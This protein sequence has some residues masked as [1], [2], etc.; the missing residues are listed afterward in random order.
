MPCA[1]RI[2]AFLAAAPAEKRQSILGAKWEAANRL[3]PGGAERHIH[4]A[5][6]GHP[7]GHE[8]LDE[9]LLFRGSQVGILVEE[10]LDFFGGHVLLEA[11]SFD[12]ELISG[13]AFLDQV[14]PGA[15]DA[16]LG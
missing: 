5:V 10:L 1:L 16:A 8:I 13:D 15:L 11:E 14:A 2:G 7:D 12:L 9:L 6:V 4:A 3:F